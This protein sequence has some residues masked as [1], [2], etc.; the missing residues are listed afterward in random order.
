[1]SQFRYQVCMWNLE[2]SNTAVLKNHKKLYSLPP[3][4]YN[5]DRLIYTFSSRLHT[6][7]IQP[8]RM[9]SHSTPHVDFTIV[10]LVSVNPRGSDQ[11]PQISIPGVLPICIVP[12]LDQYYP[13]ISIR[14]CS[15][16]SE[17]R[18]IWMQG[19]TIYITVLHI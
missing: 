8:Y 5:L 12:C 19:N 13:Y 1:M 14:I 17:N 9:C 15:L 6:R 11:I 16:T 3:I 2:H 4:L 18:K 7:T 10:G